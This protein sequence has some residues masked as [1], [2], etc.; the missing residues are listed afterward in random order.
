[1]KR[2]LKKFFSKFLPKLRKETMDDGT[3]LICESLT[4]K[5]VRCSKKKTGG[6]NYCATHRNNPIVTGVVPPVRA[7]CQGFTKDNK[8]CKINAVI[9]TNFCSKHN[10]SSDQPGQSVPS[11]PPAPGSAPQKEEDERKEAPVPP[12]QNKPQCKGFTLKGS[13]CK[14]RPAKGAEYCSRHKAEPQPGEDPDEEVKEPLRCPGFTQTGRKCGVKPNVSTGYCSKH[15]PTRAEQERK[16]KEDHK[17][18]YEE[19]L[20][21]F[22][23]QNEQKEAENKKWWDE[24]NAKRYVPPAPAV[25]GPTLTFPDHAL[26]L[27]YSGLTSQQK[28]AIMKAMQVLGVKVEKFSE[29]RINKQYRA[30]AIKYHPDKGGKKEDFIIVSDSKDL[31]LRFMDLNANYR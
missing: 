19:Y 30:G 17:N 11:S 20:R 2:K 28:N 26:T 23:K 6:L 10:S 29:E 18:F 31:L 14:S 8:P 22:A 4:L 27:R 5:G 16:R 12:P 15:D 1:M 21:N 24:Y 3:S 7:K 25:Y 13:A 9:G